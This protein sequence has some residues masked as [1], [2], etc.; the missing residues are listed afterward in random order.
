MIGTVLGVTVAFSLE[1]TYRDVVVEVVDF[2]DP[3]IVL[4]LLFGGVG[5]LIASTV[6]WEFQRWIDKTLPA[7]RIKD[8]FWG[9]VGLF[10]GLLLANLAM[11]PI[12]GLLF[13][14]HVNQFVDQDALASLLLSI[15][16]IV[17]PLTLNLLL[18]YL[19][20][21][22][23]LKKQQELY[24]IFTVKMQPVTSMAA[25]GKIL[26]SSVI[27]DG[28][29]LDL[30]PTDIIEGTLFV[31]Q[32][33]LNE[34]Q[35]LSDSSDPM[36]RSKG[37]RGFD[38]LEDMKRTSPLKLE[39]PFVDYADVEQVDAKLLQYAK[40]TGYKL[41]TND[42]ALNKLAHLQELCV[43]NMNEISNALRPVVLS[44][45]IIEITIVKKGKSGS[46]GVGFL[47]DGTMVVVE[48]AAKMIGSDVE[49][50]VESVQQSSVG[51]MAFARV[52][53]DCDK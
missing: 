2:A 5:Y 21:I 19:G 29:I 15:F 32:F 31:P 7:L 43:I 25:G 4:G 40:E 35:I 23:F 49:C 8:F 50:V 22:I 10:A 34:L 3:R 20:M 1:A 13:N 36:K 17:L 30:L 52:S 38:I 11:L 9:S 6:A 39:F 47:N 33:I 53:K 48:G 14:K 16:M 28:R 27:I 12:F 42:F 46:Q 18:G 26:D 44:G 37:K 45:E 41:V 51:R 24:S